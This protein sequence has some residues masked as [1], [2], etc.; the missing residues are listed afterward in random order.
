MTTTPPPATAST[1]STSR[2]LGRFVLAGVAGLVVDVAVLYLVL[3]LGGGH[4]SGRVLSFLC[5]VFATWQINR[6][7][8]FSG[9]ATD[10]LWRQWWH[11]L[12]AMLGGGAVNY[13]AYSVAIF[14]LRDYALGPMLAVAIGSLTGMALNFASAKW[15]IFKRR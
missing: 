14:H 6:H 13:G 12:G 9:A 8:T 7:F 11:Y 2:E 5:A 4:Y 15:L 10:S 3:A 1:A